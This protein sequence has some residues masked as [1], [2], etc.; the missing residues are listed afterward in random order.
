[1]NQLKYFL[2]VFFLI[3]L[4][5]CAKEKKEISII[6]ETS[7]ELEIIAAYEEAYEALELN[8]PYFAAKN[9]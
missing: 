6:K 2:I 3:L 8:D 1:M 9:F 7:Q 5:S 4:S